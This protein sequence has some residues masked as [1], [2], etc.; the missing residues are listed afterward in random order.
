MK[1]IIT[2]LSLH[3]LISS[4]SYASVECFVN[5]KSGQHLSFN[6]NSGLIQSDYPFGLI[7]L[8]RSLGRYHLSSIINGEETII[9]FKRKVSLT[10]QNPL[11]F[12]NSGDAS[13]G[14]LVCQ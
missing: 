13:I 10:K 1:K 7:R 5:N 3:L 6:E 4:F 9:S 2:L 8:T 14:N 12:S 11:G